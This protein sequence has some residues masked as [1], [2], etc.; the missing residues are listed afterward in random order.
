MTIFFLI[1]QIL[2]CVLGFGYVANEKVRIVKIN[3]KI[4]ECYRDTLHCEVR[5]G[6]QIDTRTLLMPLEAPILSWLH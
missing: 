5:N 4:K 3:S 2:S 1:F 6:V